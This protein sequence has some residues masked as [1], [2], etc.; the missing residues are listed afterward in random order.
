MT[1]GHKG[2]ITTAMLWYIWNG[3]CSMSRGGMQHVDLHA[4]YSTLYLTSCW[5]PTESPGTITSQQFVTWKQFL[6][7]DNHWNL[8]AILHKLEYIRII[9]TD[10]CYITPTRHT[11]IPLYSKIDLRIPAILHRLGVWHP[12]SENNSNAP[13]QTGP[14]CGLVSTKN[15]YRMQWDPHGR[16]VKDVVP[17]NDGLHKI[18]PQTPDTCISC[19][20]SDTLV[21]RMTS[22]AE[23][24]DARIYTSLASD[25]PQPISSRCLIFPY[26]SV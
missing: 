13:P 8:Q 3:G 18:S 5:K 24:Y 10:W 11:R 15:L 12:T 20:N 6:T 9:I 2:Q 19:T 23:A 7:I 1:S 14:S 4:Q 21:H 22:C 26:F 25:D 16:A 17:K